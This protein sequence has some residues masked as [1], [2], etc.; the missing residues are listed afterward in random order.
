MREDIVTVLCYG[1]SNTYGYNPVDASRFPRGVRWTSVLQELLG[2]G[3]VVIEEG[4]N[5]RTTVF[6]DP[7][8]GWKEGLSY[9]KPCLNSHKPIDVIILMLGTNDLKRMFHASTKDIAAGAE[10]LVKEIHDFAEEKLG[11]VPQ[12]I[13]MSPP[14]IG[15]DMKNSVFFRSFDETAIARSKEFPKYYKEVADKYHCIFLD[16][17]QLVVPSKEDSLHLTAG[18]HKKLAEGIYRCMKDKGL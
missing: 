6:N 5:G 17:A 8:D 18:E 1:D 10:R 4:C 14:E 16:A 11:E 3:Y 7:I 12:I 13:L 9:L 15:E 2:E